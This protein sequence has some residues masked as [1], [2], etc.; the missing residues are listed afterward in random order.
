MTAAT[1]APEAFTVPPVDQALTATRVRNL[2]DTLRIHFRVRRG[3][4]IQEEA[5]LRLVERF[6]QEIERRDQHEAS[7]ES[8]A[9]NATKA[10][11]DWQTG[12]VAEHGVARQPSPAEVQTLANAQLQ[13]DHELGLA[14]RQVATETAAVPDEP[15]R[16]GDVATDLVARAH[17]LADATPAAE[18][19]ANTLRA[20]LPAA[21]QL[22]TDLHDEADRLGKALPVASS[23]LPGN[24]VSEVAS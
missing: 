9:T 6:A 7:L 16:S 13:A 24:A 23:V 14:R 12:Y 5:F 3:G 10:L 20:V 1:S 18:R 2:G 21:E 15:E 19:Q 4:G 8:E 17:W 11:K 22:A